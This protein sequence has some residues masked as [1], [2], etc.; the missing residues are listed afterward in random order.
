MKKAGLIL[1]I[2]LL[3]SFN[4]FAQVSSRVNSGI[5]VGLG[6]KDK[7]WVPAILYHQELSLN[8]FS[9]FRISWGVRA[10]G[11]YAGKTD[12]V[13]KSSN[14]SGDALKFGKITTNSLSFVAGASIRV[15]KF[16]VG[17]NT[18]LV[19]IAFGARRR[20]LYDRTSMGEGEGAAFY[21]S[22]IPSSPS[23]LNAV[24][25]VMENQNGQS[26]L[27]VRFWFNERVGIKAGYS[28]G[29]VT[30]TSSEKLDKG[31]TRFSTTYGVPS[32]SFAFPLYN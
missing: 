17:A 16:D 18:D 8:H 29:R 11:Y 31:Q 30:Y 9:W 24:P 3:I 12:L 20:G 21:N 5:D 32:V 10:A 22:Y 14:Q 26:E 7:V 25:L 6:Y 15:W 28:Y 4:V 13:P 23:S 19:G 27:F 2:V 1:S